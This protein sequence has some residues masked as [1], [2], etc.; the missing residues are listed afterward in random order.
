MH[1]RNE[2]GLCDYSGAAK[3]S[4]YCVKAHGTE[5]LDEWQRR[6][7][8]RREKLRLS[9]T[10]NAVDLTYSSVTEFSS[11]VDGAE[12]T[13][14][15]LPEVQLI[16]KTANYTWNFHVK[17]RYRRTLAVVSFEIVVVVVVVVVVVAVVVVVVV[18]LVVDVVL[19]VEVV[20]VVAA[21]IVV[22]AVV[23]WW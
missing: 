4:N 1:F 20:L 3:E 14:D 17:V 2:E 10:R 8:Y 18:V 13:C 23:W 22:A 11:E 5:E 16:D 9:Q 19:V 12:V 21:V 6:I 15:Q 7:R